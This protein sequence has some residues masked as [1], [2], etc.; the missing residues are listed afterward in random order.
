MV[1]SDFGVVER[2]DTFE[3]D[4]SVFMGYFAFVFPNIVGVVT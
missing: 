1:V 2:S 4:I 3:L